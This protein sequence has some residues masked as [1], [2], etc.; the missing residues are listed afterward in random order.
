[1][2]KSLV[3]MSFLLCIFLAGCGK[4]ESGNAQGEERVYK[5]IAVE[6]EYFPDFEEAFRAD[7][8]NHELWH[9]GTQFLGEEPVQIWAERFLG[10]DL[11]EADIYLWKMNGERELILKGISDNLAWGYEWNLDQDGSFYLILNGSKDKSLVRKLDSQGNEV[12]KIEASDS[13]TWLPRDFCQAPDK[14]LYL[15]I[16]EMGKAPQLAGLDPETGAVTVLDKVE[17]SSQNMYQYYELGVGTKG[18]ALCTWTDIWEVDA[19]QEDMKSI[20]SF[21]GTSYSLVG[22][23]TLGE[24]E[25]VYDFRA[26]GEDCVEILR[27]NGKGSPACVERLSLEAIQRI[28]VVLGAPLVDDWFKRQVVRFNQENDVYYVVVE[29]FGI[30]DGTNEAQY[31]NALEDYARQVSIQVAT[32]GGPDILMGQEI[33]GGSVADMIDKGVLE[34]LKPYMERTGLREE[35]YFPV[36]FDAW[37]QGN[38]IYGICANPYTYVLEADRDIVGSEPDIKELAEALLACQEKAVYLEGVDSQ[39][40]LRL[41][42]EGSENLWGMVDWEAGTCEFGGE[43]FADLLE[44]ARRYGDQPGNDFQRIAQKRRV[45]DFFEAAASPE[46]EEWGLTMA[47]WMFDEGNCLMVEDVPL[48]I[49]SG[50]GQKDGAWEFICFLL[51]AEAQ[52]DVMFYPVRRDIFPEWV[53]KWMGVYTQEW[54]F[55]YSLRFENRETGEWDVMAEYGDKER[56]FVENEKVDNFL[57]M[58]EEA[59]YLPVRPASILNIVCEEAEQYF[60]GSKS[61][62]EVVFVIENR[63]SLYLNERRK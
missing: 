59:R 15:L 24:K 34:D 31:Q 37:R 23:G 54:G 60:N 62:E 8:A 52:R 16:E 27:T 3:F 47:G 13:V 6:K 43:L 32:G 18:P 7:G 40:L 48:A 45:F 35:D 41:F 53:E 17:L 38:G 28:P 12:F 58:L 36:V 20:L 30:S 29:E 46:L 55:H 9:L 50:S 51:G 39:G 26:V 10:S 11:S 57:E 61:M 25:E 2:K 63:V 22:S 5:D 44:A 1:M 14:K 4:K 19:Q 49:N 42:L 56:E 33:L 21:N